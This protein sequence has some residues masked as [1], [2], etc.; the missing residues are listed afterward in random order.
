VWVRRRRRGGR[1]ATAEAA[2]ASA[3]DRRQAADGCQST[4]ER[5]EARDEEELVSLLIGF[6]LRKRAFVGNL[7][8]INIGEKDGGRLVR[9]LIRRW[10]LG[11][12]YA[13]WAGAPPPPLLGSRRRR[14][15]GRASCEADRFEVQSTLRCILRLPSSGGAR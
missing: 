7:R 14:R 3:S 13:L 4:T 9:A 11:S 15:I 12:C 6:S 2:G 5:G 8:K 1:G 10:R